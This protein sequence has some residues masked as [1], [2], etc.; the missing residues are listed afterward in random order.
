M[1][2]RPLYPNGFRNGVGCKPP[3]KIVTANRGEKT[4][5]CVANKIVLQLQVTA[6]LINHHHRDTGNK[7][8]AK[9]EEIEENSKAVLNTVHAML[10]QN[11]DGTAGCCIAVVSGCIP[12]PEFKSRRF[13]RIDCGATNGFQVNSIL[14]GNQNFTLLIV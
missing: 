14:H 2:V 10:F 1:I 11:N 6:R 3:V 5:P 9:Q 13:N 4:K 12:Y 8:A 7:Q